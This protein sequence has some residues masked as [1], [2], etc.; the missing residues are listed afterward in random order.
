MRNAKTTKQLYE[1]LLEMPD[2]HSAP[3][4][5]GEI[6]IWHLYQNAYIYAYCDPY[7]A[8]IDIVSDSLHRGSLVHWHPDEDE[9]FDELYA[10]GKKGNLLVLKKSLLGT[11]TFYIGPAENCPLD[12]SRQWHF[13]KKKWDSGWLIYLEQKQ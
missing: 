5:E 9:M 11:S 12:D 1:K 2:L 13:G 3:Q 6:L 10:L 4:Q 7:D 8:C